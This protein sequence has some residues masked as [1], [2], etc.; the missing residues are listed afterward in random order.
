[1][2]KKNTNNH[3]KLIFNLLLSNISTKAC[4]HLFID[5]SQSNFL[6]FQSQ[7]TYSNKELDATSGY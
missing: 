3:H 6:E 1:M 4:K 7:L 5:L 2:C